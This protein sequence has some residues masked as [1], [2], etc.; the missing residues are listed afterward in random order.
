[1]LDQARAA[2]AADDLQALGA[3]RLRIADVEGR[4]LAAGA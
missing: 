1:L 3:L 2:A 4:M